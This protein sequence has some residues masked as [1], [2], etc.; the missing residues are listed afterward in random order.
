MMWLKYVHMYTCSFFC[1]FF[2]SRPS[3][4]LVQVEFT[5]TRPYFELYLVPHSGL[6][7][8]SNLCAD[9]A[10][11]SAFLLLVVGFKTCRFTILMVHLF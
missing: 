6:G 2:P 1:I 4:E 8:G 5:V 10:C 9:T 3:A 11:L 7:Q